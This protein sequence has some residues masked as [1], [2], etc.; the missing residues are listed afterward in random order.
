MRRA[1]G[2]WTPFRLF[3]ALS[4]LLI[5]STPSAPFAQGGAQPPGAAGRAKQQ[6]IIRL[7]PAKPEGEATEKEKAIITKHFE[8]L[9]GLLAEG[10]LLLA[11]L[12]LDDYA[13]IVVLQTDS[14]QEAE[15]AMVSDPAVR[16][17]VFLA[18]LHPFRVALMAGAR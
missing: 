6:F 16:A 15:L 11:G 18:E 12:A 4:A 14:Q 17:R 2:R 3:C 5:F 1:S 9:Q 7:R 8:Y 10:K 13:G